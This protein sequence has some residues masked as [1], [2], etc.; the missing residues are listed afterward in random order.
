V[1]LE[2]LAAAVCMI[3]HYAI[4]LSISIRLCNSREIDFDGLSKRPVFL[5]A[6]ALPVADT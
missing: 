2:G 4:H 6:F 1:S 5:L 3:S